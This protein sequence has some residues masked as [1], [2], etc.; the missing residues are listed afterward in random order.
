MTQKRQIT[1]AEKQAVLA[2]QGLFCFVNHHPMEDAADLEFDHIHPFAEGGPS[3][4]DNIAAVC[5]KHNREKGTLTLSEFR[6]R[7]E[8][9]AFFEGAKKR[10]LDDLLTAKLGANGF[11]SSVPSEAGDDSIQLFFDSGHPEV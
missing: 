8:L 6:D 7:L 1:D 10:R 9:R 3:I 5:K 4:T 11:A 2:K